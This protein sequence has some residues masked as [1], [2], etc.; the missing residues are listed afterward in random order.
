MCQYDPTFDLKINL[1]LCDLYFMVHWLCLI[2]PRLFDPWVSYFQIMRQCDPNFD[3]KVVDQCDSKINLVKYMWVND[4]YFMVY[5]FYLI[6][7]SD[8]NYFYTLRNGAGRGIRV[9][10]GTCSSFFSVRLFVAELCPFFDVFFY[11]AIISLWNLVNKISGEQLE[12]G[13]WYL[14]HRLCPR[15]RWPD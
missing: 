1:G 11:F 12:L 3:L 9:P 15:C 4:L 10:L 13:S 14:A 7:L 5:W 2:S 8:L 6:S